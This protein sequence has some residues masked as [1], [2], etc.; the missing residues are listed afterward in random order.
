MAGHS[1]TRDPTDPGPAGGYDERYLAGAV[2]FNRGEYFEA[3]E[4]WEELWQDCPSADRRFYQS[5]I[6]AAVALYHWGNGNRA[7]A[8]RL[9]QSGRRY[10][11]PYRPRYRGLDVDRFWR[12][13]EAAMADG[14][15]PPAPSL[16]GTG[17]KGL[18]PLPDPGRG[19]GTGYPSSPWTRRPTGGPTRRPLP[20]PTGPAMTDDLQALANFDGTA[21]LFP[22]PNLVLFP[23]VVQALHIFEPRY[24]QLLTDSLAA[25]G[26]FA[27]VLLRPGPEGEDDEDRPEIEPVACLG[28]VG[29]HE[30]LAD[31]RFNLKLRGLARLRLVEELP[32]DRPYRLARAELMPDVVPADLHR[33]AEIRRGLADAVLPRFAADGAAHQQLKEL[34]AGDTPLGQVCDVLSYALPLPLEMKQAL[35]A[36]PH[37]N[38]RAEILAQA[39]QVSAARADRKFPPDFSAN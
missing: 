38:L 18:P 16:A 9:F 21:R 28:R 1:E 10:M 39:L 30:R 24:R 29:W 36:E 11:E 5:L 20:T 23:H 13:V 6:Q 34:F 8:A 14:A 19:R 4:V 12:Q 15:N 37:V 27:M 17:E 3:H 35:L 33:L 31:G 32:T 7:G 2:W 22:L 26:T 25:D